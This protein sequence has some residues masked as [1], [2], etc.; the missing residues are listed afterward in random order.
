M[1]EGD[2]PEMHVEGKSSHH[3]LRN[4]TIA[5]AVFRAGV[6][7]K[8]GTDIPRIKEE[9]D[10]AG[11]NFRYEQERGFT[12]LTFDRPGSQIDYIDETGKPVP[13][14]AGAWGSKQG[15][16]REAA[17]TAF[18]PL[19]K[20]ERAAVDM[21]HNQGKVTRRTLSEATGIGRDTA[22]SILRN[23]VDEGILEWVGNSPNDP[24]QYY[25]LSKQD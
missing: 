10:K 2:S 21:A 24:H 9:C 7:E 15:K 23:L 19:S 4:A 1:C 18:R 6:I 25:R 22:R 11:V 14:P 3:G 13:P 20:S 8:F 17:L 16:T 12:T 5:D